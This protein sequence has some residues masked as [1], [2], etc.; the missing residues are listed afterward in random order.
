MAVDFPDA[1]DHFLPESYSFTTNA[2]AAIVIH[3]TGGD[4]TLDA[5]YNTFFQSQRSTH[6][7]IG[8]DGTIWQFVP[9]ARGAGGNCCV[10]AGYDT[11]WDPYLSQYQN[12]NLCTLSV[13]HCDPTSD[14]SNPMP[15]A[16]VDTSYKLVQYWCQKYHIALDHIKSHASI[17]PIDRARC[18]GPTYDFQ[19]LFSFLQS[20]NNMGGIPDGW[21][22]DGTTLTAPNG[23]RV[24][25]GF[26]KFILTHPWK[27][28][29]MPLEEEVWRDTLEE[30]NPALGAGSQQLFNMTALEYTPSRGVFVAYIGRELQ[31]VRTDRNNLQTQLTAARQ[32]I[33]TL[34]AEVQ[35]QKGT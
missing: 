33:A 23:H 35:Q 32:Q 26:R 11:F 9:E 24:V 5:V 16:Q 2:A 15:Q 28:D 30:S 3:K 29:D 14:N 22:D 20:G 4:G 27:P 8:L 1:L 31:F 34:Q 17:D 21:H 13:E 6:Y 18:P 25:L 7:A 19:A 10:Q 12:L